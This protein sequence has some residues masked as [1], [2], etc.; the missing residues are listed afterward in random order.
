MF[1]PIYEFILSMPALLKIS[2]T[3]GLIAFLVRIKFPLAIAMF[4]SSLLVFFLFGI[5][6]SLLGKVFA[7]SFLSFDIITLVLAVFL[8]LVFSGILK[9][10]GQLE[11]VTYDFEKAFG[12]GSAFFVSFPAVIGLMPM[13]GGAIFS[14]PLI[15]EK[16]KI[17]NISPNRLSTINFWF[18]HVWEYAWILYPGVIVTAEIFNIGIGDMFLHHLPLIP[19]SIIVGWFFILRGRIKGKSHLNIKKVPAF[20]KGLLP[21]LILI[22]SNILFQV[23]VSVLNLSIN[24]NLVLALCLIGTI[25]YVIIANR[26]SSKELL[27][28]VFTKKMLSLLLVIFMVFFFKESLSQGAISSIANEIQSYKLPFMLVITILPFL[29]GLLSGITIGFVSMTFPIIA[30]LLTVFTDV[31]VYSALILSFTAGYMGVMLSPVHICLIL[32]KDYYGATLGGTLKKIALPAIAMIII[33]I[34]FYFLYNLLY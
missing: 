3:F 33:S 12:S 20:L 25:I 34:G 31:S 27:K 14:A 15:E 28:I 18:R 11:K 21:V 29:A 32:T 22:I 4:I 24:K 26:P 17:E 23:I 19:G 5:D 6:I 9:V 2:L 13:P 8:I 1:E 10:T 7:D 16:G 30:S